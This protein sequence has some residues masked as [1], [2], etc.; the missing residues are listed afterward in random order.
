MSTIIGDCSC[1]CGG[2]QYQV[3]RA[4]ISQNWNSFRGD[5]DPLYGFAPLFAVDVTLGWLVQTDVITYND[6]TAFGSEGYTSAY[7]FASQTVVQTMNRYDGSIS[8]ATTY[9]PD[10]AAYNARAALDDVHA[11]SPP[12]G[13][14]TDAASVQDHKLVHYNNSHAQEEA[15]WDTAWTSPFSRA[16]CM[17]LL[18]TGL[19]TA[20]LASLNWG[21]VA[22]LTFNS[23]G[24]L[25][26]TV[27]NTPMGTESQTCGS[28]AVSYSS[29]DIFELAWN[30]PAYIDSLGSPGS[31]CSLAKCQALTNINFW[32]CSISEPDP[33]SA[34]TTSCAY[35]CFPGGAPPS[36]LTFNPP[37]AFVDQ[38]VDWQGSSPVVG[39]LVPSPPPFPGRYNLDVCRNYVSQCDG[40]TP[41]GAC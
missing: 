41:A 37:A 8:T 9:N 2:L 36:V 4:Q 35:E 26:T 24:S 16:D 19:A 3:R 14:V 30:F 15:S 10:E 11:W 23:D 22:V 18:A 1:G 33:S 25:S 28:T 31:P 39:F 17:A 40:T 6:M 12:F 20:N 7:V 27:T 29:D 5:T 34:P 32:V 13:I 38:W 21:D